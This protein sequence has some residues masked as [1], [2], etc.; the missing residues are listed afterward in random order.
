MKKLFALVAVVM[1]AFAV[2]AAV[3]FDETFS[4]RRGSTYIVK[5]KTSSGDAWPYASQ[6][7]TGYEAVDPADNV[8]GNQYDNDYTAVSSYTCSVRGKKLDG[9]DKNTVGLFFG[10]NKAAENNYVKFEGALPTVTDNT[11]LKFVVCSSETDGGDLS[12]MIV[13]VNDNELT[14]PET[15]IGSKCVTSTVEIPL[16]AG[17]IESLYFAFNNVPA[18]KFI[19]HFWIEDSTEGIEN[20]FTSE[21]AQKVMI[22]GVVYIVRDGKMFNAIGAQVR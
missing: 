3:V 18:Q 2:N 9:S 12:T 1:F 15:T 20:V 11:V 14:V 10:A 16:T 19:S 7:F 13:K 6:W 17:E 4:T 21:K 8:T 22:D 5:A